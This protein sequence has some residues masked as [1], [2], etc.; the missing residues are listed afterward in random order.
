MTRLLDTVRSIYRIVRNRLA[1]VSGKSGTRSRPAA[2]VVCA[3]VV[4]ALFAQAS[5]DAVGAEADDATDSDNETTMVDVPFFPSLD[6]EV[7]QG[8][9]RIVNRSDESGEILI[10]AWD[11]DGDGYSPLTLEID[12]NEVVQLNADDLA[13]G[14]AEKGLQNSLDQYFNDGGD[15]R[16]RFETEL[17]VEVLA[18]IRTRD[19][20]L[21]AMHDLAPS[22]GDYLHVP[23][24]NPGSNLK[25]RSLLRLTNR[26]NETMEVGITGIDDKGRIPGEGVR[27]SL[28]PRASQT[29]DA[30][31]LEVG[32]LEL[33]GR[34]VG[35]LELGYRDLDG[36]LGIGSGKWRLLI[37]PAEG[38][39][40][41]NLL[42]SPTG[43]LANVS[44]AVVAGSRTLPEQSAEIH[45]SAPRAIDWQ[46]GGW[47]DVETT[48]DVDGDGDPDVLV[49]SENP[50]LIAWYENLGNGEFSEQRV[51]ALDV[52]Y[53]KSV[54]SADLDG[55][56]DLDVLVTTD[57]YEG[58]AW[59]E[60][61]GRGRFSSLRLIS[62]HEV[63][64][65]SSRSVVDLDGDGDLDPVVIW[66][67]NEAAW[68]ENLGA[69]NFSEAITITK[70]TGN[71]DT[72]LPADLDGDGDYDVLVRSFGGD[73]VWHE[74][75]GGGSFGEAQRVTTDRMHH[76]EPADLDGDG[77]LDLVAAHAGARNP[78]VESTVFWYENAGN[79]S[80]LPRRVIAKTLKRTWKIWPADLDGDGDLDLYARTD[81]PEEI[82]WFENFGDGRFSS[83]RTILSGV[84]LGDS[85]A[86]ADMDGD[87]RLDVLANQPDGIAWYR[88]LGLVTA[89]IAAPADVEVLAGF[90]QL[91]VT[92]EEVA[93]TDDGGS[94][95]TAYVATAESEDDWESHSCTTASGIGCT[96]DDLTA[97]TTYE[98]SVSALNEAG[99]GPPSMTS[100]GTP[101][102]DPGTDLEFTDPL[103]LSS[104]VGGAV[105]L[106]S[107]DVDADG[108]ADLIVA[109][110][111][112][113]Q[114]A[115][116]ENVDGT[117]PNRKTI[118]SVSNV[119]QLHM[120]DLD[121][122]RRGDILVAARQGSG[123]AWY[124]SL[125]RGE[126]SAE[127]T[128][129]TPGR[130]VDSLDTA[131]LDG[132]GDL[133]VLAGSSDDGTLVWYEN[134][135]GTF[136]SQGAHPIESVVDRVDSVHAAD[137]DD[138]GDVDVLYGS[139][140]PDALQWRENLGGG[141]FSRARSINESNATA[142][143]TG[144][145]D[146]D[147]DLDVVFAA[148]DNGDGVVGWHE[149]SGGG[150]FSGNRQVVRLVGSYRPYDPEKMSVRIADIDG[151]GDQDLLHWER[152]YYSLRWS[153]NLDGGLFSGRRD[154]GHEG[155][156][157]S[158][159]V[160]DLDGDGDP[161]ALYV[162]GDGSEI[163]WSENR[164]S[165]TAPTAAAARLGDSATLCIHC[166][167]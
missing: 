45:F 67:R 141:A 57:S 8:I 128:I 84:Y 103:A 68:F 9:V 125:G 91:W 40:A 138:D 132:D 16:F 126:F 102:M 82:V 95:V 136:P 74:N 66:R 14:N 135:G 4:S 166:A 94:P 50:A 3:V 36:K 140:A 108:D 116:F 76:V 21:T 106:V 51:I 143:Q 96:I 90:E 79:A 87:G 115:W 93:K 114:L 71:L 131:D 39:V 156:V 127:G 107:D 154:F 70:H 12:G 11:N 144:D 65:E 165:I 161:D 1:P 122:D 49:V 33:G 164:G 46:L 13:M 83:D 55:D 52:F 109:M 153:E 64:I 85:V 22:A 72:V 113:G 121:G 104:D 158:L 163:L 59:L 146:G 17:D 60:N 167:D 160:T 151:D 69:G 27:L 32:G 25:Q 34:E 42:M 10:R 80:F 37:T 24:F 98:V 117:F 145:M 92:W 134:R 2:L 105:D 162:S 133:E 30:Q 58:L 148:E 6:D 35:G 152:S 100:S 77:D 61:L 48:A 159:I 43:H 88:N 28:P 150:A 62:P 142:I 110:D 73:L 23:L 19:G 26:T 54:V 53:V 112:S 129:G 75:L 63:S 29:L 124:R 5:Q 78:T 7:R 15:W 111:G 31:S 123:I 155:R 149:N 157:K 120:A 147:G 130:G 56:G 101:R 20:F 119:A 118:A 97:G 47:L 38:L 137:L 81:D 99:H 139:R 41:M 86:I 18:Y 89:P 44:T